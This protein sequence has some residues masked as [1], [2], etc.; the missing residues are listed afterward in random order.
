MMKYPKALDTIFNTLYKNDIRPIIVG[1][2]VRD[3]FLGIESNDIDIELYGIDSLDAVQR[4]L[5]KFGDVNTVGKSFGVCKLHYKGLDL[6]FSLPRQDN[7][8]APGHQ[9]FNICINTQLDFKTAASRRDFTINAIGYDVQNAKVLDPYN[10]QKDLNNRI[11]RAVDNKKFQED[12]L[13]VLRAVVFASR[14]SMKLDSTLSATCKVM[15]TNKLL[16]EL[17]K[18]RV[19]DEIKK[20]LL[21]SNKPSKGFYLFKELGAFA[22][23]K[24]LSILDDESFNETLKALDALKECLVTNEKEFII[25]SLSVLSSKLTQTQTESFLYRLTNEKELIKKVILLHQIDFNLKSFDT[26]SVYKLATKIDIALYSH[27][28]HV[29]Q[30]SSEKVI[31]LYEKAKELGV[32][33]HRAPALIEG[34]DL[35]RL[36]LEPSKKFSKILSSAYEAQLHQI[37]TNKKDAMIWLK[38]KLF[39]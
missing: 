28:L 11:L 18:E 20:L 1:G 19:F 13:R 26:Y 24:E 33:H 12:P 14:F 29:T 5:K 23:F 7:K 37:F 25:L 22:Y 8:T 39:S 35:I 10:G 9:G 15:I 30:K 32:L 17:P 2:Y 6:D 4:V 27:Y 34:K 38:K 16:E 36:G 31:S 3:I 21:K